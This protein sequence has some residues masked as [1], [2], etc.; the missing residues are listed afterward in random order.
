VKIAFTLLASLGIAASVYG[1][2]SV[3]FRNRVAG[4]FDAPMV[5]LHNPGTGPGIYPKAYA[6]LFW[7]K[8][9]TL[10]PLTPTTTFLGTSGEASKYLKGVDVIIPGATGGE[11]TLR[12]RIFNGDCFEQNPTSGFT[13]E[14]QN[15]TAIP[16]VAPNPPANLTGLGNTP[17][18]VFFWC[19]EPS[20][21]TLLVIG[22]LGLAIHRRNT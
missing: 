12:I 5:N 9:S 8:E 11:I 6:Q 3:V 20:T 13:S 19:P 17:I 1:Q 4:L 22:F 14:S 2:G 15:F 18:S 16:A 10:I 7:V 21:Y